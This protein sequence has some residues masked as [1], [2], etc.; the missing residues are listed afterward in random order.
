MSTTSQVRKTSGEQGKIPIV[1]DGRTIVMPKGTATGAQ[2]RAATTPPIGDDRDLWLDV[3][4]DLDRKLADGDEIDLRPRMEF[5]SV[6]RQI[7]PGSV[8]R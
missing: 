7:N 1:I 2:L 4:G 6:P 5:F 3:D 8:P